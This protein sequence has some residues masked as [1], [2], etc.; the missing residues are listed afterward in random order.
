MRHNPASLSFFLSV[1]VDDAYATPLSIQQV[2]PSRQLDEEALERLIRHVIEAEHGD[3]V[4]LSVVLTDHETVRSLNVS[5]LDHDYD[6]D[7]LSF[8]LR[9]AP[10]ND[11]Q[12][13]EG[14]I[15]IDLDTAAERHE[16]FDA[17]FAEEAHRYVVHGL[18]H[19]LGY[20]DQTSAG[21]ETMR[22]LEDQYLEAAPPAS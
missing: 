9:D 10:D 7:V 19:L 3:L 15:Y 20:D 22:A 16:E 14:E 8:S 12:I 13:V 2:H 5:Y 4:H 1:F 21:Q 6:T 17:S 11:D 18:L